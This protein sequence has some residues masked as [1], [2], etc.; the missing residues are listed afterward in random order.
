MS[1]T[2]HK[3]GGSSL[4]DAACFR[5]VAAIVMDQPP[6]NACVVVSAIGGMTDALLDLISDA[7]SEQDSAAAIMALR[8]RYSGIVE[9]L[10]ESEGARELVAQFDADVAD[11]ESVLKALALVKT[12][13]NR[14]R[15]MVSGFGE[16]W[17]ARLLAALLRAQVGGDETVSFIDARDIL[18]VEASE[19]GVGVVW[20][21]AQD[22]CREHIPEDFSGKVVVTGFIARDR[23]GLQCNL[24]RNGSD[25][26][27]SIFGALLGAE[28]V[29][30]WTDVEGVMS[31]DPRRVPEATVIDAIS[32]SEAMELAYFGAKVI[33]PQ[34]MAPAVAQDIP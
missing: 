21:L 31:G 9:A 26:S 4:A 12:A 14:S 19:M 16:L 17:S 1:W 29:N 8:E 6:G 15:D 2:V 34:T 33:H 28:A 7:S 32:Y 22:R 23:D 20:E 18:V 3:F 30:I 5:R 10:L 27:A 24:G 25:Y 13:S 11:I